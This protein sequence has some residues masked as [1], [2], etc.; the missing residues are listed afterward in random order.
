M[1]APTPKSKTSVTALLRR[2]ILSGEKPHGQKLNQE[3]IAQELKVSRIPV[4][5]A[6]RTLEGAGL[7]TI[8]PNRGA[9]VRSYK[10]KD[11]RDIFEIRKVLEPMALDLAFDA[12][13]KADL[14][15]AEDVLDAMVRGEDILTSAEQNWDFH[16]ILYHPCG[17]NY[18]LSTLEK[19]HT[20]SQHMTIIGWSVNLR[21]EKSHAEHLTILAACR[22]EDKAQ[23]L[24]LTEDH[25]QAAMISILEVL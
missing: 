8:K 22:G 14:G 12:I 17:R 23:A 5:E 6:F 7:V 2:Q 9:W 25:I 11:V 13:N 1:K 20:A 10:P 15:A 18:L 19:L 21:F 24:A 4:R 3:D 16:R